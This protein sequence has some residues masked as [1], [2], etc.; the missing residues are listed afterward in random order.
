MKVKYT[1]DGMH[2]EACKKALYD[3]VMKIDGVKSADI[4][5]EN[6]SLLIEGDF[7]EKKVI[8]AVEDSGFEVCN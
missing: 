6:K 7:D 2:C 3:A 4:S 8:D 5:L 1:V